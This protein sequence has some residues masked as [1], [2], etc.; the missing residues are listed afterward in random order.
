MGKR[1]D[2]A[3]EANLEFVEAVGAPR[4]HARKPLNHREQVFGPM[5]QLA[6]R[7][8]EVL[9][10]LAVLGHVAVHRRNPRDTAIGRENRRPAKCRPE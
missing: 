3:A 2:A 4:D 1:L 6:Q 7:E 10:E 9:L 5:R 8:A